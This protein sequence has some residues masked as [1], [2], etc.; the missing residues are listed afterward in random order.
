ME[1]ESRKQGSGSTNTGAAS[2]RCSFME[3]RPV[4][5]CGLI[6]LI[7]TVVPLLMSRKTTPSATSTTSSSFRDAVGRSPRGNTSTGVRGG[8]SATVTAPVAKNKPSGRAAEESSCWGGAP[9]TAKPTITTTTTDAN[10]S[11]QVFAC[12]YTHV[13]KYAVKQDK[14]HLFSDGVVTVG[15]P[16][17][18]YSQQSVMLRSVVLTNLLT[19]Q[20]VGST[21]EAASTLSSLVAGAS[22][23]LGGHFVVTG[24]VRATNVGPPRLHG[25]PRL[26]ESWLMKHAAPAGAAGAGAGGAAANQ[27]HNSTTALPQRPEKRPGDDAEQ[28]LTDEQRARS[29]SYLTGP[30]RFLRRASSDDKPPLKRVAMAFHGE[31]LRRALLRHTGV[32]EKACSNFFLDA[33]N[34]TATLV[35]P[36]ADMGAVVE[37]FF[38]TTSH[39][40]ASDGRLVEALRPVRHAFAP[41]NLPRVVDSYLRV[42]EMVEAYACERQQESG[43]K[44]EN[45]GRPYFDA[46]ILSRFDVRFTVHSILD[47][48]IDWQMINVAFRD[49]STSWKRESK[50]SDLFFVYPGNRLGLH[51]RRAMDTSA[52]AGP[53]TR[54]SLGSSAAHWLLPHLMKGLDEPKPTGVAG[55]WYRWGSVNFIDPAGRSSNV[56]PNSSAT[57]LYLDRSCRKFDELASCEKPKPS[58]HAWPH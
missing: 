53:S 33:E 17:S 38:H 37:T 34:I 5:R 51:L 8:K 43:G 19:E 40:E 44:N 36:L 1:D 21:L 52:S 56:L 46:V 2:N 24:A 4:A 48:N 22:V 6:L 15:P 57:F 10:S 49:I 28:P 20:E 42:M 45:G 41:K 47:L 50:V 27:T 7:L 9:L 16:P 54:H 35:R 25:Q 23:E 58:F 29:H 11:Y 12:L 13:T 39:C 32:D 18:P 55:H 14:L 31:Y 26:N 3:E 30:S